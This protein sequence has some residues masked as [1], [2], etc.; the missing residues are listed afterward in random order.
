MA[1]GRFDNPVTAALAGFY[2]RFR[3]QE[4]ESRKL[5]PITAILNLFLTHMQQ[6]SP[7]E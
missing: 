6:N 7:E 4:L 2:D 3:K 1:K 5:Y